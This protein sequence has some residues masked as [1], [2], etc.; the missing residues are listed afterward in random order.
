[1]STQD[2]ALV[3][4]REAADQQTDSSASGWNGQVAYR[5]GGRG[6]VAHRREGG[7][8]PSPTL[9]V[10]DFGS[11]GEPVGGPRIQA[12]ETLLRWW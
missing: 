1:M 3:G 12:M 8:L 9:T 5:C 11:G 6:G 7:D 4:A 2:G 10:A